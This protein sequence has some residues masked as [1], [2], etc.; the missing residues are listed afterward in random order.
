M[1]ALKIVIEYILPDLL[2]ER[3]AILSR[4]VEMDAGENARVLHFLQRLCKIPERACHA[5]QEVARH[6]ETGALPNSFARIVV[7][8]P[9]TQEWPDG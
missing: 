7:A 9:L 1:G 2:S 3:R 6:I 5:Q 4:S 8:A